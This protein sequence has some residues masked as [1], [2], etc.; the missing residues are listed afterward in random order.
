MIHCA[1]LHPNEV[2][3]IFGDQLGE[4]KVWDLQAEK[5]RQFWQMDEPLVSI[6][7]LEIAHDASRLIMGNSA[8]IFCFWESEG[9]QV[10]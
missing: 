1:V 3:I 9:A 6:T 2:E 10:M 5:V 4:I 7:S 8:G